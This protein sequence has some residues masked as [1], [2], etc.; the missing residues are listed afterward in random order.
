MGILGANG[1]PIE[2]GNVELYEAENPEA[3]NPDDKLTVDYAEA[4]GITYEG[5]VDMVNDLSCR[6]RQQE[7]KL[8]G[9]INLL[10][11]VAEHGRSVAELGRS[12]EEF[13]LAS[14]PLND[15]G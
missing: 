5:F 11:T 3:L 8:N 15:V 12:I 9:Y 7:R 4:M 1:Q 13:S 6:L 2:Y 10:E 14:S